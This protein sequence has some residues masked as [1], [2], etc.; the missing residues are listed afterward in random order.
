MGLGQKQ[1]SRRGREGD[2]ST[3]PISES[4]GFSEKRG[5]SGTIF[6]R[7]SEVTIRDIERGKGGMTCRLFMMGLSKGR[8]GVV[9]GHSL[10]DSDRV[11]WEGDKSEK[12]SS[13]IRPL[14]MR[15]NQRHLQISILEPNMKRTPV[16]QKQ[17]EKL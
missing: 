16:G 13:G 3:I 6:S 11:N 2:R 17:E 10:L 14:K 9:I 1:T 5:G 7:T 12:K 15:G 4:L 8:A